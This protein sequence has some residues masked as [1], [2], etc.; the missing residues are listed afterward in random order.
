MHHNVKVKPPP[1]HLHLPIPRLAAEGSPPT[2]LGLLWLALTIFAP[3]SFYCEFA[4]SVNLINFM[5]IKLIIF[6]LHVH[7]HSL[8]FVCVFVFFFDD[9]LNKTLPYLRWDS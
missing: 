7:C 5:C 8:L 9:G 1:S 2:D 6:Y 4:W 3:S